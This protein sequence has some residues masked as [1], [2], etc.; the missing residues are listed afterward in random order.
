MNYDVNS[1]SISPKLGRLGL[2]NYINTWVRPAPSVFTNSIA[3]LTASFSVPPVP[4]F[5]SGCSTTPY[6][7]SAYL[8]DFGEPSSGTANTS[9][10]TNPVHNY[11]STGPYTVKLILYSPC[12][13][14]TVTQV[15]NLTA[16]GP[17]IAVSGIFNICK[18]EK[19]T[20]TATG[21]TT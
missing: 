1:I 2:P 18:G 5:S 12:V 14:D 6:V 16:P 3:C 7:P 10:L 19:R 20:F 15:V 11:S 8:W 17:S 9:T 4:T 21:G 13:N